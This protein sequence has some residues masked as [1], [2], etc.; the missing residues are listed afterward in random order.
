MSQK[1]A[2]QLLANLAAR[3]P[4]AIYGYSKDIGGAWQ[5]DPSGFVAAVEVRRQQA[6]SKAEASAK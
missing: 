5:K 3:V 6:A 1:N 4:W 2:D